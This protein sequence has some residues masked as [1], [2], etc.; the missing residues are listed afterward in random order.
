MRL[1]GLTITREKA[2]SPVGSGRGGWMPVIKEAFAGAWQRNIEVDQ[3][4]V[5]SFHAVY[6]CTTLIASDIAKLRMKLVQQDDDGI[7]SEVANSAYS[8]VL[9]KPNEVQN[10]IQF[11]EG[12]I[13]SKLI[14]GNTYVLKRRDSRGVVNGLFVLDPTRVRP[15]VGDDGSVFY[16]IQADNLSGIEQAIIAPAREVIHDRWNCLFHPLVGVSA[17][18]ANGLAATQGLRIQESS[19]RFFSNDSKPGGILTAPGQI[20]DVTAA[21][22]KASWEA[23]FSGNNVGRVAVLGD[24]LKY[25]RTSVNATDAQLIEQLK[26]TADVVCSTFHVPPYKIGIGDMPNYN[27]IQSLNVEYYSQCLQILIEAAELCMDEGLEMAPGIGTEFDLD[28][29][30]R[31]D[32]VTQ[33]TALKEAV[34]AKIMMPNEARKRLDLVPSAGGDA[35][36]GQ[37]QDYSLAALAKRDARA[38]PFSNAPE[39]PLA[40]PAPANDAAETEAEAKVAL[41]EIYKG[42]S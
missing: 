15:M 12:W 33:I 28:G 8:P 10:R 2:V 9:R 34:G 3:N 20:S 22:L 35:L 26:W 42:L 21:R 16:E 11:W 6:A 4:L 32:S 19:A 7:W 37:H 24:G 13:L 14:H 17:I 38:D 25:E 39:S 23:N 18:Y 27:N 41:L 31:M 1:F 30:L 5:L 40:L 29:L 36:Y